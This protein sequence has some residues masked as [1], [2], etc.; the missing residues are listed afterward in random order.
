MQIYLVT[1][2]GL[3]DSTT[4]HTIHNFFATVP[5]FETGTD[6]QSSRLSIDISDALPA[7]LEETN[8]S[9]KPLLI[10]AQYMQNYLREHDAFLI[11]LNPKPGTR[12]MF[13]RIMQDGDARNKIACVNDADA[14]IAAVLNMMAWRATRNHT[15]IETPGL[16]LDGVRCLPP[17]AIFINENT[18]VATPTEPKR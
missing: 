7:S 12:R 3:D 15:I 13:D 2:E 11:L 17:Y 4:V 16:R 1:G 6:C 9:K 18:L 5:F 14:A 10:R 8:F